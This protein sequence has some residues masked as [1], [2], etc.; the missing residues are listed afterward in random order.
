M[1]IDEHFDKARQHL[2]DARTEV[3]NILDILRD[4]TS[5]TDYGEPAAVASA[6]AAAESALDGMAQ[7]WRDSAASKNESLDIDNL[8]L[9]LNESSSLEDMDEDD[10]I[11]GTPLRLT[12]S[13]QVAFNKHMDNILSADEAAKKRQRDYAA[14]SANRSADRYMDHASNRTRH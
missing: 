12:E 5:N 10:E 7:K 2:S 13:C 4:Y 3:G 8:R 11:L 14:R 6:I 1:T 9:V